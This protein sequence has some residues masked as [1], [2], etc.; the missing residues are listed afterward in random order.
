[1]KHLNF[2]GT[3]EG[4]TRIVNYLI[5]KFE[6][7]YFRKQNFC[8]DLQIE[9]FSNKILVYYSTYTKK[10]LKPFHGGKLYPLSSS[11]IVYSLEVK[12]DLFCLKK[13]NEELLGLE[14]PYYNVIST[15]MYLANYI[16]LDIAFFVDLLVRYSSAPTQRHWNKVNHILQ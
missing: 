10:V 2:V 12:N 9:Y 11:M 3:L 8:L 6:I 4:L 15:L 5:S 16:R 13:D 1:M 14:V 7:K